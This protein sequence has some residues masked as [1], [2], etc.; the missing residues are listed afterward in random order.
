MR[1]D[2]TFRR[3]FFTIA[4]LHVAAVVGIYLFSAWHKKPAE[5]IVWLEGG[6]IGGGEP[7]ASEPAAAAEPP[8]K[9]DPEP[10]PTPVEAKPPEPLP[11]PP[12]ERQTPSELVTPQAT[13]E[14][15][16][17][18]PATPKPET[19][20]PE[21]PKPTT[22]KPETPKPATPKRT[23]PK[24]KATPKPKPTTPKPKSSE[25]NE[26]TPKPK[27]SPGGTPKGTSAAAKVNGT[28]S[29]N[30]PGTTGGNGPGAGN[31]R[32]PGKM[33]NGS[34]ESEFGWYFAM[35]HDRFHARW[36]QPTSIIRAGQDF[37]TTLKLR[38]AKDGTILSHE[39]VKSSGDTT[40]D[41]SVTTA[42]DRVQQIE[43]LPP[44]LTTGDVFEVNVAFKLDQTQ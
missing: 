6:S 44:G 9:T 4:A 34:G 21:T 37:V 40:M 2:R 30:K 36:D 19:P 28:A 3:N 10:E 11:P 1:P 38:I 22:P 8:P 13:P 33:G 26:G 20:R 25:G 15:S 5:Q 23:T 43:A 7:G 42:A 31:G 29:G 32:G 35:L 18:K 41:Q 12:P 24:P 39:I 27:A 17:P 16:T 14:P